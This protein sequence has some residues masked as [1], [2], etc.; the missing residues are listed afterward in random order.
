MDGARPHMPQV[1]RFGESALGVVSRYLVYSITEEPYPM[2]PMG[3]SPPIGLT[4]HGEVEALGLLCARCG[5]VIILACTEVVTVKSS[6]NCLYVRKNDEC[7]S[8]R[9]RIGDGKQK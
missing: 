3:V 7:V 2:A 6:T 1:R 9:T 5:G 4:N 8:A